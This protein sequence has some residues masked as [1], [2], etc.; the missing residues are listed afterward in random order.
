MASIKDIYRLA[1]PSVI[2]TA[3]KDPIIGIE[4]EWEQVRIHSDNVTAYW[5]TDHDGSLRNNG[6][7]FISR[8]VHMSYA[9]NILKILLDGV[10]HK[11]SPRCS[12]HVH[13]DMTNATQ[14]EVKNILRL[15]L[16]LERML[17]KQ[18]NPARYRSI[19]C[20][21]IGQTDYHLHPLWGYLVNR[22]EPLWSKYTALNLR[23]LVSLGTIE[24]RH[25]PGLSNLSLFLQWLEII[26]KIVTLGKTQNTLMTEEEI[27]KH[28]GIFP[29]K[30]DM[31]LAGVLY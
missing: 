17:F 24:F 30:R 9:E 25:F 16:Q 1:S 7:E 14:E 5:M 27:F 18:V 20:I 21:P 3:S 15:Y 10:S 22:G 13:V 29:D 6:T 11:V 2:G 8:P 4:V 12:T 26:K 31:I 19:F 23:P 28:F